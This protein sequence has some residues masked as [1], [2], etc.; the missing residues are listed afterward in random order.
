MRRVA[1]GAEI[2]V[3]CKRDVGAAARQLADLDRRV[4]G[5]FVVPAGAEGCDPRGQ[6]RLIR[7]S[8]S[9]GAEASGKRQGRCG[10]GAGSDQV[11]TG[12]VLLCPAQDPTPAMAWCTS[13]RISNDLTR[14]A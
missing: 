8:A 5:R 2:G 9:A 3:Q 6:T 7:I 4:A 1:A 13:A 12:E 10:G 14:A 11:A